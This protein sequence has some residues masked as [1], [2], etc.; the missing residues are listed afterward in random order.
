MIQYPQL[1]KEQ[2]QELVAKLS[3]P[4]FCYPEWKNGSTG[5]GSSHTAWQLEEDAPQ[6]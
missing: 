4:G 6:H 1:R 5:H 2:K 3:P